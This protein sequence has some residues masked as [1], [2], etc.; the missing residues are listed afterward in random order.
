MVCHKFFLTLSLSKIKSAEQQQ[1]CTHLI[2]FLFSDEEEG[3]VKVAQ[4]KFH[5]FY[6]S[7][8][9][10]L[11][12]SLPLPSSLFLS[13]RMP[14]RLRPVQRVGCP[15]RGASHPT[16]RSWRR[17]AGA[18]STTKAP[19]CSS[20]SAPPASESLPSTLHQETHTQT[21]VLSFFPSQRLH[22]MAG[23]GLFEA[24]VALQLVNQE[25][26]QGPVNTGI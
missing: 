3:A 19:A 13:L 23:L 15:W 20:L 26:R 9:P 8:S 2:H 25:F 17:M 10:F 24:V 18:A 12:P 21:D 11:P 4:D 16:L 6:L 7:L 1:S 5:F 14:L 22:N